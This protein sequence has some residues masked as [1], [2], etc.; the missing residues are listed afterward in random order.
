MPVSNM[1][2]TQTV[3]SGEP[4]RLYAEIQK[5]A[6]EGLKEVESFKQSWVNE[7]M[8]TLWLRTLREPCVQGCDIWRYDYASSLEKSRA[9]RQRE[10]VEAEISATAS[11]DPKEV[12][13]E[14]R[15]KHPSTKLEAQDPSNCVSFNIKIS[16]MLL[17]VDFRKEYEVQH[18]PGASIGLVQEQVVKY[19]EQI[20]FGDNL[21]Y[22]LVHI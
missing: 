13:H 9:Q 21:E 20:R 1:L 8:Q 17:R 14:F 19:L 22:L 4:P 16:G 18:Q 7:P 5:V 10:A 2:R 12:I 11:R 6:V 3:A 15:E